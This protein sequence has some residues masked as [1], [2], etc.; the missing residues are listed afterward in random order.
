MNYFATKTV[1][2]IGATGILG[3]LIALELRE[4]GADV[5]LIVRSPDSLAIGLRDLPVAVADIKERGQ[6][7][8]AFAAISNGQS[9]DGVINCTGVVAF[10]GFSELSDGVAQE[11]MAVNALGVINV[12]SLATT[13]LNRDGFLASFTGVAADM[14]LTGMGAY[15]A[16]K[17]AA[18]MAMSVAARELRRDK[19]RVLDIRPPHIE[20]GL[21]TRALEGTAP[22]MPEGLGPQAVIERVLEAIATG[23][24]DLPAGAFTVKSN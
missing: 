4:R 8:A 24:T 11:L 6:V 20:T 2:V 16:S 3:Q 12:I 9:V 14:A 1:V 15:C 23:E 17:A 19:I 18:K 13:S 7:A 21:I 5:R 22:R 10:G